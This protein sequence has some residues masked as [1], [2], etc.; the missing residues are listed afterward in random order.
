[1]FV[2]IAG[3]GRTGS[4][5]AYLLHREGHSVR[6]IESRSD[7]LSHLHHELPTESI[8]HGDPCNPSDLEEAG[9]GRA[10]VLVACTSD[11]A[12]NLV[13]CYLGRSLFHVPRT[14]AR[15]NNPHNAWLFNEKFHVDVALSQADILAHLIQE[16][17]SLGDMMTL[18]KL[19]RGRYSLVEEKVPAG[20][21][22]IGI[23]IKDLGL[24]EECVIAAIIRR[25]KICLPRGNSTFEEGDEILAVTSPEAAVE[26]AKLLCPA[27]KTESHG[28]DK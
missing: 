12:A 2:C 13:V 21:K 10:N 6:V 1:M 22:A 18:L 9:L 5:L 16:E 4:R 7:L 20:A 8:Y 26:L 24:P 28:K 25:G 17:M 3:G 19:R 23:P 14:I 15:V 11:D 27:E